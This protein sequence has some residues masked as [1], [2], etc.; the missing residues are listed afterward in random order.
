MFYGSDFGY[1]EGLCGSRA[2][3]RAFYKLVRERR[4]LSDFM[5]ALPLEY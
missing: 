3:P 2:E 5:L 1:S 4:T